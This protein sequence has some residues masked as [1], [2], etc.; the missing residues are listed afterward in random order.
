M[1]SSRSRRNNLVLPLA[2][3]ATAAAASFALWYFFSDDEPAARRSQHREHESD[4]EIAR[5]RTTT[6]GSGSAPASAPA[7]GISRAGSNVPRKSIAVVVSES[8][9][10]SPLLEAL[11]APLSFDRTRV[12][13]LLYAPLVKMHPLSDP[14]DAAGSGPGPDKPRDSE[15]QGRVYRQARQLYPPNEPA[16][17]LLPFSEHASLVPML[18]HIEPDIV[19][20]E[21]AL[22]GEG[23]AVV[24]NVLDGGRAS[25]V[26]SVI[27][28]VQDPSTGQRIADET[29]RFGKRCRVLDTP[30]V[31]RDWMERVG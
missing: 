10:L 30:E 29:G 25:S 8:N 15:P 2:L 17:L 22:V 14:D 24:H 5:R 6:S 1:T 27:V 11:P 3:G 18:K 19:Y 21:A 28:A 13:I 12:F 20:F 31:G 23:S 16:E 9:S 4:T 7:A 26:G